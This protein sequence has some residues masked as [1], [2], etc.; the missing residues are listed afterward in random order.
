MKLGAFVFATDYSISPAVL[1]PALEQRGFE[2]I[3]LAEHTHIPASRETPYPLAPVLP[4]RYAHTL[5]PFVTL[6]L[7]AGVTTRLRLGT[8]ICIVIEHEPIA[9]A[10]QVASV[11]LVS[12]GRM[13]F[14]VGGGWNIEEMRNMGTDPEHRFKLLRE[15][16]LAMKQIWTEEEATFHGQY[17]NFDRI[18]SWPKPVQQPH[19][20]VLIGSN[21]ASPATFK[22]VLDY[23][24]EWLPMAGTG[25]DPE[26][27]ARLIEHMRALNEQA[28]ARGRGPIPVTVLAPPDPAVIGRF[29]AAGVARVLLTVPTTGEAETLAALDRVAPLVEEF[30]ERV[31]V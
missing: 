21:G 8:G 15:R 17:V 20:P 24:D 29:Q 19:P 4:R 6:A 28:A 5:D 22:R 31:S 10:K 18:W 25:L 2:S 11:D 16:V 12:N 26:L 14:G 23:G 7:I 13:L 3:F 27:D 30:G 1:G 9:L